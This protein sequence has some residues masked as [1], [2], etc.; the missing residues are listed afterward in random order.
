M[1]STEKELKKID[2]SSYKERF[3]F[4]LAVN[5]NIICQRYFKINKFNERSVSSKEL[6]DCIDDVVCLIKKELYEKSKSFLWLTASRTKL[7]GF[8]NEDGYAEMPV[9]YVVPVNKALE[10]ERIEEWECV[11]KFKFLVDERVVVE[12]IWDGSSY[13]KFIRNSV[14]LTNGKSAY[15]IIQEINNGR[16]DIVV[17]II[18]QICETCSQNRFQNF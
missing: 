18:K 14:D 8:V 16:E 10:D 3:Q 11:F 4:Q 13:P 2:N 5:N 15:P 1:V 7:T 12:Q 17:D 9:E 6:M